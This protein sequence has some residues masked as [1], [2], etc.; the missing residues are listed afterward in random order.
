MIGVMIGIYTVWDKFL[1]GPLAVN[2]LI[3][4]WVATALIGVLVTPAALRMHWLGRCG[5]STK[6]L[7]S[8]ELFSAQRHTSSSSPRWPSRQ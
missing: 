4:E 8:A 1:V 2:P 7:R 6:A 5:R 3:L